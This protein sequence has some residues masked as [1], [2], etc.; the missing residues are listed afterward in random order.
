MQKTVQ[1]MQ[2]IFNIAR[3]RETISG[4]KMDL[5]NLEKYDVA[6]MNYNEL[7]ELQNSLVPVYNKEII[8]RNDSRSNHL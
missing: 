2:I 5:D 3:M 7:H 1:E 8:R 6:S 4:C